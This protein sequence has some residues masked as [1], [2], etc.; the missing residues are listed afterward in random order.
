MTVELEQRWAGSVATRYGLADCVA[1][2]RTCSVVYCM[3]F[4]AKSVLLASAGCSE[5]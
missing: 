2:R 1:Y 4:A 5:R 3:P